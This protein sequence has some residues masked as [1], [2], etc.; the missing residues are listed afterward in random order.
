MAAVLLSACA[1]LTARNLDELV[2]QDST[3]HHPTTL[4]PYSGTVFKLFD[5]DPGRVQ[6][7]ARL[8]DGTFDGDLV[9]Y[10]PSGRVRFEGEMV[11]GRQCGGWLENEDDSEPASEA[12]EVKRMLESIVVYPACP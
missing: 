1:E 9:V 2:V 4:E 10:H 5:S 6:L 12:E 11:A 3:Y 8:E 7:R